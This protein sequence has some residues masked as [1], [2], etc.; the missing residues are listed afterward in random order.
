MFR[1]CAVCCLALVLFTSA[2]VTA[3]SPV[4][5]VSDK[6][7]DPVSGKITAHLE[8]K[9][10]SGPY[11]NDISE[12]AFTASMHAPG[13]ARIQITDPANPSRWQVP[14]VLLDPTP[15]DHHPLTVSLSDNGQPFS[16]SVS[17]PSGSNANLVDAPSSVSFVYSDQYLVWQMHVPQ[18]SRFYGFGERVHEYLLNPSTSSMEKYTFTIFAHDLPNPPD[19]N[20]YG[21]HPFAVVCEPSQ[22]SCFGVFLMNSNAMDVT[23]EGNVLTFIPIGGVIDFFVIAGPHPEMVIASYHQYVVG[24][25]VLQPAWAL[26]WHQSRY[27]Y[28]SLDQVKEMVH[29]YS[30]HNLP[31]DVVWSDIDYMDA[32]E[33]FTWD[34]V[35][36]P[37]SDIQSFTSTLHNQHM[38]YVV[39]VDP[40]IHAVPGYEPYESGLESNVFIAS[41]SNESQPALG[42]VWPGVC[43]FPD[44]FKSN[45]Q[46]WWQSHLSK[47]V[48]DA[49]VDGIWDDMNEISAF[50][51]HIDDRACETKYDHPPFLP[52]IFP[53]NEG[54]LCMS[55]RLGDGNDLL[56]YNT[57]SMYGFMETRAIHAALLQARPN[58]RPFILSRS[59][60]A[61]HGRY[62]THWT[63]DNQSLFES[64][65]RSIAGILSFQLYGLSVVGS[66]IGG[67]VLNAWPELL[68]RWMQVGTFYPFARNHNNKGQTPQE[69]YMM[70]ETV[71]DIS[72]RMIVNRLA[73]QPYLYSLM[74]Q[75]HLTGGSMVRAMWQEFFTVADFAAA[76]REDG[77][78]MLGSALLV[79]PVM[80][81]LARHKSVYFPSDD[82]KISW[83]DYWTGAPVTVFKTSSDYGK[84][85]TVEAPLETIPVFIRGGSVLPRV[86]PASTS[87]DSLRNPYD[88]VVAPDRSNSAEG[89]L[90]IDDGVSMDSYTSGAY[91]YVT[92]TAT[93]Q[94]GV[95][96]S[97]ATSI[98]HDGYA[99][100]HTVQSIGTV[101]LLNAG[102]KKVGRMTANGVDVSAKA[103]VD[104]SSGALLVQQLG[105]QG[106]QITMK[107][108]CA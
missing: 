12:L 10:G 22:P 78:Y 73:M 63:G 90:F 48:L 41:G 93:V 100:A 76:H 7:T 11:G 18:G 35:R 47:F 34:P 79:A 64:M 16:W 14:Y 51:T 104:E 99:P 58:V 28:S 81:E 72:R 17:D 91:T 46:S 71:L 74:V 54:T 69:P 59:S 102:C 32:Y 77:Q 6:L 61:G 23:V 38:R 80:E 1:L 83:Y 57:H 68:A 52:G 49:D 96:G 67:F 84:Y 97:F 19:I 103:T 5:T 2:F 101:R 95:G 42:K 94:T 45:T 8:L 25:A 86:L 106:I 29:N 62:G 56:N 43:A 30:V 36:Y 15:V 70:G 75:S 24:N 53:L 98:V 26:G 44:F 108:T 105:I 33:D 85:H 40:G 88:F 82:H 27:G 3:T 87:Y 66:D 4:Y 55:S 20:N 65:R 60:Y 50:D 92:M 13:V 31:L 89:E 37:L 9:S 39:I 21:A 107:W